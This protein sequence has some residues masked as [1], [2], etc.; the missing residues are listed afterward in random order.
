MKSFKGYW[1]KKKPE[2]VY[3]RLRTK[4]AKEKEDVRLGGW[5]TTS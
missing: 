2:D 4:L 3:N 5:R 1:V